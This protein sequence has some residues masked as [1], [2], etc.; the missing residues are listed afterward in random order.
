MRTERPLQPLTGEVLPPSAN[1]ED[2]ARLDIAARGFW[3]EGAMAF[4]DV[5]VFNPFAKTHL[6][7]KLE[8][9]FHTNEKIKKRMYNQRVIE[10]EHGS[11][12][13]I[14]LSAYGGFGRETERLISHLVGKIAE[15]KDVPSSTIANYIRA[16]LSFELVKAQVM[17]I[18]GSRKL[19]KPNVDVKE[20]EV[21]ECI[22]V[23]R[24]Q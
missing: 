9:A 8:S 22:G 6:N 12:S 21:V 17:C 4:F 15:K 24:E 5:K 10:V 1:K 2:E 7:M 23:I 18:R 11:F 13:P 19:W 20:A 3:Q 16:K 14:V